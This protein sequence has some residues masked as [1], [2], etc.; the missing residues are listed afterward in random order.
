MPKNY[1]EKKQEG[2]FDNM[3]KNLKKDAKK[4]GKVVSDAM[5]KTPGNI[6]KGSG[7]KDKKVPN[8]KL[9]DIAKSFRGK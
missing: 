4:L 2:F 8:Q 1:G 7:N 3:A 5:S 6:A 9:E